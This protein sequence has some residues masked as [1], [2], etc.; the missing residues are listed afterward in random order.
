MNLLKIFK[1]EVQPKGFIL[2][3]TFPSPPKKKVLVWADSPTVKTG[4]GIVCKEI[5]ENLYNTNKYEFTIVGINQLDY[6][7]QKEF[8]YA[9][10]PARLEESGDQLGR[11]RMLQLLASGQFDILWTFQDIE[12]IASM[13]T[14]I[15]EVFARLPQKERFSLISYFPMDCPPD[16][17]WVRYAS[18]A[19]LS[20][21][22]NKYGFEE[23]IKLRPSFKKTLRIIP[24]GV[25]LKEIHP[26]PK[27]EVNKFRTEILGPGSHFMVLNVNRNMPRKDWDRTFHAFSLFKGKVKEA[28]LCVLSVLQ[29]WGGNLVRMAENYNLKPGVDWWSPQF[30]GTFQGVPRPIINMLYNAADVLI[31]TSRGEGWGLSVTEAFSTKTPVLAPHNTSFPE[32]ID[33]LEKRGWF[34]KCGSTSSEWGVFNKDNEKLRPMVNVDDMVEKLLYIY[35]HKK[36]AEKKADQAYN[37]I[38]DLE[39]NKVTDKYWFP[40]FQEAERL[41]SEFRNQVTDPEDD[42]PCGSGKEYKDCCFSQRYDRED[43]PV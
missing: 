43:L 21:V 1:P 13:A 16:K 35:L 28:K 30:S 29:D 27:E 11:N 8:P 33:L 18:R 9:I 34:C 17:N 38:L 25:N 7:D 42:C 36:E 26:L 32:L 24:H 2:P 3:P 39:W 6:Y 15:K 41:S 31:T 10:Y 12:N 37:W 40:Y 5:L 4:F 22:Y 23:C 20:A 14:Q 19:H